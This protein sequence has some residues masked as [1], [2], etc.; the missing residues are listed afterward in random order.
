MNAYQLSKILPSKV[1]ALASVLIC[2]HF[3]LKVIIGSWKGKHYGVTYS[4]DPSVY[5]ATGHDSWVR[6]L[7]FT[8][9][10]TLEVAEEKEGVVKIFNLHYR[11][12]GSP[13]WRNA[14]PQHFSVPVKGGR[15]TA[16]V[17][18]IHPPPS[19]CAYVIWFLLR[20]HVRDSKARFLTFVMN[21]LAN[22]PRVLDTDFGCLSLFVF[23]VPIFWSIDREQ[24]NPSIRCNASR[25]RE[26]RSA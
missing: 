3:F 24:L 21:S 18:G 10:G 19:P 14:G 26:L 4:V 16:H 1:G 6:I 7:T 9:A 13:Q 15:D 23:S 22:K 5:H 11:A 25:S 17:Q 8:Q 2:K 20:I 12:L